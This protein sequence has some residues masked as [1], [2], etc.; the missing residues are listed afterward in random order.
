MRIPKSSAGGRRR[1]A[2]L[3]IAL[4]IMVISGLFVASW[5]GLLGTRSQ[6]VSLLEDACA[7]RVG[8]LNSKMIS[9]QLM[10]QNA[11]VVGANAS[12]NTSDVLQ[13]QWGGYDVGGGWS[14]LNVFATTDSSTSMTT[15]FPYNFAAFRP[16]PSY[17]V[18]EV[19][20]RPSGLDGTID[21][22]RHYSFMKGVNPMIAGD[23]FTSYRKPDQATAELDIHATTAGHHAIWTVEGRV[24]VRDVDSLFTASTPSP[25]KI[26][27]RCTSL[28]LQDANNTRAVHGVDRNGTNVP[29]SNMPSVPSTAGKVMVTRS[30]GPQA[31]YFG[32]YLN[33]IQN[34]DNPDNSLWH[35][36]DRET[37]AG[38]TGYV[39]VDSAAEIGDATTPI[40]VIQHRSG[41][42]P[43]VYPPFGYPG[44]YPDPY[45]VLYVRL[46]HADQTH[47]RVLYP[48]QDIIFE[49]QSTAASY[50]AAGYAP[51]IIV[52]VISD[53]ISG[54]FVPRIRFI[55]ENN[56]RFILALKDTNASPVDLY[57][58]GVSNVAGGA[59]SYDWRMM[60]VNEYR[61]V[62]FNMPDIATRIVQWTGGV[63]TNWTCKRRSAGGANAARLKFV[64]DKVPDPV[65]ALGASFSSLLPRDLCLESYFLAE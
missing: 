37:A 54:A 18:T 11:F 62:F 64:R 29:A 9:R 4:L 38:R 17:L 47:L 2:L 39:T 5:V 40:Q 58:N 13:S 36:M 61:G 48:F 35:F 42:N 43:P 51:P 46:G 6:Q 63:M 3:A 56:R 7:R 21:P 60:M 31:D 10:L 55:N 22:F 16:V 28:F 33:V 57:W 32:N 24:V 26:P 25:L 8:L 34:D 41:T 65:G 53:G 30:G 20:A 1:G 23:I 49:G 15:V 19:V 50:D 44:V 59:T 52:T 14:G 45:P 12:A 27:I